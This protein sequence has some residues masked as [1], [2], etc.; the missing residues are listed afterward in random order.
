[1]VKKKRNMGFLL[2]EAVGALALL[3]L[4]LI[5]VARFEYSAS[6][7]ATLLEQEYVAAAAAETQFE[8]LTVG[9][10]VL[11]SKTFTQRYP[12]LEMEYRPPSAEESGVVTIKTVDPESRVLVRL[13]GP[14]PSGVKK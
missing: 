5:L 10:T 9:L 11:D 3:G 2:T 6:Q 1:M 8:R 7:A 14:A 13:V 12:G 4:L